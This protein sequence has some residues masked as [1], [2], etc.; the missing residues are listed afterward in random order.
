VVQLPSVDNLR[1]FDAAARSKT[2]REAARAVALTPAALGQRIRQLEDQLGARLFQRTTRSMSLT[3]AG[4]AL[5]PVARAALDA[6]FECVRAARGETA[7]LP[8]ELIFGTRYELGLSFFVPLYETLLARH[9]GLSLHYYFGSGPDLLLRV[10]SREVD[11]AVTSARLTDPLLDS[12][13]LQR[14]DYVFV[15]ARALLKKTPVR[16]EKDAGRH[17][18]IDVGTELPL[19]RYWRDAPGGGDRLRFGRLWRVGTGEAI[20][21]MVVAGRGVA[22]L[23]RY[24][25]EPDLKS[26][27]LVQVFPKVPLLFD[28]FRLVFRS[29]D[30]RRP[31][32]EAIA[33]TI[34]RAPLR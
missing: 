9:P 4:A 3:T 23:P 18:L 30:P 8:V 13:R 20:R 25:V 27:R 12:I 33:E 14:E 16:S 32:F 31:L 6:A 21:R 26:R 24:L 29:D 34:Q 5:L 10:R 22:V 1:C 17:A 2:F 15:G 19:F 28:H 11:C 7:P